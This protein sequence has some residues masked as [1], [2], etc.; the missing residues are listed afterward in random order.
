MSAP[1]PLARLRRPE[2]RTRASAAVQ[3]DGPTSRCGAERCSKTYTPCRVTGPAGPFPERNRHLS[4]RERRADVLVFASNGSIAN[5][6]LVNPQTRNF[7]PRLGLAYS[8]NPKTVVRGGY[9]ISYVLFE[10][11]GSDSYLAYNGPFVVNAQ[12]T[13][14]PS[15]GLCRRDRSRRLA[16]G[17]PQGLWFLT[18]LRPSAA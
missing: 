16:S 4:E 1:D 12:I 14:A 8:P 2:R 5:R 11:Q 17:P 13:Q 10:R 9:G 18:D 3:G 15:Q 6:A 7:G